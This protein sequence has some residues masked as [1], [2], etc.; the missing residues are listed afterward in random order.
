SKLLRRMLLVTHSF[1]GAE[2]NRGIRCVLPLILSGNTSREN[3]YRHGSSKAGEANPFQSRQ[4]LPEHHLVP[5]RQTT[6]REGRGPRNSNERSTV[7]E[8]KSGRVLR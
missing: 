1:I 4:V 5:A 7:P 3:Q 2:F 8:R 6:A